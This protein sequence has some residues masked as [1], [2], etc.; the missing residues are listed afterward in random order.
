MKIDLASYNRLGLNQPGHTGDIVKAFHYFNP[1][2]S[3]GRMHKS[4][5]NH[6]PKRPKHLLRKMKY[7]NQKL[8]K[9]NTE[10]QSQNKAM[11]KLL[12]QQQRLNKQ[13]NRHKIKK[14][15]KTSLKT[16]LKMVNFKLKLLNKDQKKLVQRIKHIQSKIA[17]LNNELSGG[18]SGQTI[19]ANYAA[20][21]SLVKV[22]PT[23][24]TGHGQSIGYDSKD[25]RLFI[26]NNLSSRRRVALEEIDQYTL[27][28]KQ[29]LATNALAHTLAY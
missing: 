17:D 7:K 27:K 22:G 28:I 21:K 1:K 8:L 3:V 18:Q 20:I 6:F 12:K 4:D 26:L 15:K 16:K 29:R 25:N 19:A 11:V 13:L 24:I 10:L 2:T 9:R 14:S 5:F 23:I